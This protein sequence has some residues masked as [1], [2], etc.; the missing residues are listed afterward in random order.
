MIILGIDPG[1]QITGFG[2]IKVEGSRFQV[3]EAGPIRLKKFG[4]LPQRLLH[5]NDHL[6]QLIQRH[7]PQAL[8]IEKVFHGVNV[9]SALV[10]GHVRGVVMMLAAK[11]NM[12][13]G[14][15]APTQVKKSVTGYGRAEKEQMQEVVRILLHLDEIPKPND[16]ADALAI[17]IC[18]A[19]AA[20]VNARYQVAVKRA[21]R[22]SAS[23]LTRF[24][25]E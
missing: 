17:A 19:H 2:V 23:D 12:S 11:Y 9:Q 22:K 15:Y 24:F 16:V 20:P 4:D 18:H 21:E 6:D 10:L 3:L 7:Q 5:L 13:I 14:E 8:A 25:S 1:S